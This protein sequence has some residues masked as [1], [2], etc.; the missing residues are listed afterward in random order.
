MRKIS[1]EYISEMLFKIE[2]EFKMSREGSEEK[3]D[4]T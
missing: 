1:D 2:S 4:E 3:V